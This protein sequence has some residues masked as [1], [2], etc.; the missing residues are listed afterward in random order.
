MPNYAPGDTS[1]YVLLPDDIDAVTSKWRRRYHPLSRA[2]QAHITLAFPP[3]VPSE[4]W[5]ALRPAI[6]KLLKGFHS[7]PVVVRETGHFSGSPH[8]LWLRPEDDGSLA[9]LRD[10]LQKEV[11]EHMPELPYI[12]V[13][14][15]TVGLLDSE[16]ATEEAEKTIRGEMQPLRFT[17]DRVTYGICGP[18]RIWRNLDSLSLGR[19]Q[20][21]PKSGYEGS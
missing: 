12:F 1:L 18:D 11:P 5:S 6:E 2:I 21:T 4:Q 14:H 8:V 19:P 3:F 17:I 16:E 9:R 20:Q 15:I 10:S 13:P 7:F